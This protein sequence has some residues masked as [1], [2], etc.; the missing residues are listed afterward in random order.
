MENPCIIASEHCT[1]KTNI[2]LLTFSRC[3]H[4]QHTNPFTNQSY[5][6]VQD[7]PLLTNTCETYGNDCEDF[8]GPFTVVDYTCTEIT[9]NSQKYNKLDYMEKI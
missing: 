7:V 3:W 1:P 4:F 6:F 5:G 8:D 2:Y 9:N